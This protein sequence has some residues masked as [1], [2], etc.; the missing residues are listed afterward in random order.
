MIATIGQQ[1]TR[2][3]MTLRNEELGIFLAAGLIRRKG[4][5]FVR[6]VVREKKKK[7]KKKKKDN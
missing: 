6:K 4:C 3:S 2:G 5:Y 1:K 7:K